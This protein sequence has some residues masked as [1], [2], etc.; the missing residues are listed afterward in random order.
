MK[1]GR[2]KYQ[3]RTERMNATVSQVLY[4]AWT[5]AVWAALHFS[6]REGDSFNDI[7]RGN[8]STFLSI[9][10]MSCY[11]CNDTNPA[12]VK[13][14]VLI[15]ENLPMKSCPIE[16]PISQA[17]PA[18]CLSDEA[19]F[20]EYRA[21]CNTGKQ[22]MFQVSSLYFVPKASPPKYKIIYIFFQ[23]I[24]DSSCHIITQKYTL[25]RRVIT[26]WKISF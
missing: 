6:P 16:A 11:F 10:P 2:S 20:A 13:C 22:S 5:T 7:K 26:V 17:F 8:P 9:F 3:S 21:L 12:S 1:G 25:G 23:L 4:F 24:S 19:D 14:A 15:C 18:S